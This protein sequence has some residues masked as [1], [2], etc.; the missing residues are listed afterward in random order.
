M[1][2][3]NQKEQD[4]LLA[5]NR[6]ARHDYFI[7]ESIEAG[8]VLTG[9]EVKSLRQ[10]KG[11]IN[12]CYAGV[13]GEELF[14]F[15]AYIPEYNHAGKHLQ[16]GERRHRKLLL[17]RKEILRL[18]GLMQIQG[19]T[20][21]PLRLYFNKRGRIKLELGLARGKKQHDKREAIKDRDWQRRKAR[22]MI[23]HN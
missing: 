18:I 17:H 7:E 10:G 22:V 11:S 3:K 14:L 6:K 9:T 16:H 5:Q 20:L 2:K 13:S 12:E 1:T 19:Y 21:I 4:S 8:I 23:D 15:N